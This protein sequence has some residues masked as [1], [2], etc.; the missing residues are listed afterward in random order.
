MKKY[1]PKIIALGLFITIFTAAPMWSHAQDATTNAP[2][3]VPA[4]HKKHSHIPFRGRLTAVDTNAMTFTIKTRTFEITSHTKIT[5][6]G[7]PAVLDDGVVGEMATGAYRKKDDGKLTALSLH[8]HTKKKK[9]SD[10]NN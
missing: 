9:P 6:D 10:G 2:T 3:A 5:K 8:F 4:K 7:R 1:I